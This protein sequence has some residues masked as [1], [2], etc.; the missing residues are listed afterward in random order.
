MTGCGSSRQVLRSEQELRTTQ[1]AMTE[2][3]DSM[4][5]ELRDTVKEV[6]MITV[7]ENE[8]GDTIRMTTVTDRLRTRDRGAI[9]MQRTKVEVKTDTVFME[10]RDSIE[11]R[12]RPPEGQSSKSA[13]LTTLN[14]IFLIIVALIGLKIINKHI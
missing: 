10:K 14:W 6:T 5:I 4:I 3:R 9:A 7:R 2:T 8:V 12:S 1:K 11:I 13:L